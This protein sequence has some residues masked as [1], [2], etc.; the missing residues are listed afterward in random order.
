MHI[1]EGDFENV[2]IIGNGF[3]INLGL[4]TRY[5]DFMSSRYFTELL[6]QGNYISQKLKD[7]N[8]D[9]NWIDIENMLKSFSRSSSTSFKPDFKNVC[10]ALCQYIKNINYSNIDRKSKAYQF[11]DQATQKP[12]VILDYNYTGSTRMILDDLAVSPGLSTRMHIK[13]HG[14]AHANN[15]IFGVEDNC[16]I[17]SR[18]IY[19]K[20]SVHNNFLGIDLGTI[21]GGTKEL[22]IFG[23]SLGETDHTY[24]DNF[25]LSAS[26]PDS[27]KRIVIHHYGDD[28]GDDIYKQLDM[29]TNKGIGKLRKYNRFNMVNCTTP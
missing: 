4:K 3:D 19:L 2:I 28:G 16:D 27:N 8:G 22:H 20:K 9:G 25:F 17:N 12:F 5:S 18:D 21:M 26:Y 10:T 1:V 7:I 13:V 11:L 14:D 29:L 6:M 15:I 23:H 24:F